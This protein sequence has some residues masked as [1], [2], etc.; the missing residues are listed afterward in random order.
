MG[1]GK[2]KKSRWGRETSESDGGR[3]SFLLLLLQTLK[4]TF[5][6]YILGTWKQKG[7]NKLLQTEGMK[8]QLSHETQ[9]SHELPT[10]RLTV[11]CVPLAP[12]QGVKLLTRRYLAK[13]TQGKGPSLLVCR[14]VSGFYKNSSP[15]PCGIYLLLSQSQCPFLGIC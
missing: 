7:E 1:S 4:V 8:M 14:S 15:G 2:I 10:I 13:G 11:T 3:Q 6:A 12:Q 5:C 9:L